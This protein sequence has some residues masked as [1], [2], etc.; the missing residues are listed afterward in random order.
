MG[1]PTKAAGKGQTRKPETAL[2]RAIEAA[3]EVICARQFCRLANN[4][5]ADNHNR[6]T[7]AEAIRAYHHAMGNRVQVDDE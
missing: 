7:A 4:R 1:E 5:T 3:A 2:D 6:E